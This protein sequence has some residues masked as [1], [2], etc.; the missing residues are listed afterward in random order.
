MARTDQGLFM[1][2]KV[3]ITIRCAQ[4]WDTDVGQGLGVCSYVHSCLA[5]HPCTMVPS[6]PHWVAS[7]SQAEVVTSH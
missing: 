5:S 4:M 3:P 1:G 7:A 2:I 6:L